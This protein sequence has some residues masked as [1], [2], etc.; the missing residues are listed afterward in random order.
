MRFSVLASGSGG[1][2]CYVETAHSRIMI[3]AGL[4]RREMLRR[5]ELIEVNPKTLDALIITHEHTDHVKGAGSLAR[6]LDIPVYINGP[7]FDR[8]IKTLGRVSKPIAFHTGQS[9]TIN[10]LIIETFTK[11]HDAEDPMGLVMCSNGV[12][13]GLITDL[14]RSTRLVEDRLK[15]CHS[16][17]IEFNYDPN[18]LEDGPYPLHLKKR[19]RGPEGHLSNQQAGELLGAV[20]HKDLQRVVL[21]HLSETNNQNER[22]LQE[23]QDVLAREGLD[24]IE[25]LVSRQDCPTPIVELK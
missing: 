17:I 16:L 25:I 3:D 24:D 12:R 23:A 7:T 11:C 6:L 8:S 22:A 9:I 10:D 18:M 20:A 2:A 15:N 4:S 13:L 14:G 19:I 21:A 1:N 5:L